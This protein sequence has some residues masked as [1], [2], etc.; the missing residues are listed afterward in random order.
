MARVARSGRSPP[1]TYSGTASR[2]LGSLG[3]AVVP[4][5]DP[6]VISPRPPLAPGRGAPEGKWSSDVSRLGRSPRQLVGLFETLRTLGVDLYL[7]QRGVDTTSPA[8]R[9]LLG[10]AAVFAEFERAMLVARTTAGIERAR[11]CGRRIGRRPAGGDV[12]AAVRTPHRP[13]YAKLPLSR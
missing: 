7:D 3:E 5:F 4:S 13:R 9:A 1:G 10:M 8:G 11:A 6:L 12:E 2:V